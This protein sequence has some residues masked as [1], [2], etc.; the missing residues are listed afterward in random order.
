M[1]AVGGKRNSSAGLRR[2]RGVAGHYT[3]A[4][5]RVKHNVISLRQ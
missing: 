3:I 2:H 1:H 5:A 4:D